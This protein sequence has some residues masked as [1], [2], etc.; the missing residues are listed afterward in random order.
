MPKCNYIFIA[1][2]PFWGG[3][4]TGIDMPKF[5]DYM[6]AL[7]KE[8]QWTALRNPNPEKGCLV[9]L[10]DDVT[11]SFAMEGPTTLFISSVL[12]ELPSDAIRRDSLL[13]RI[14]GFMVAVRRMRKTQLILRGDDLLAARRL[15]TVSSIPV[16]LRDVTD[17][18]N[19]VVWWKKAVD[20]AVLLEEKSEPESVSSLFSNSF[21]GIRL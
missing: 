19:D 3:Q 21:A 7:A 16:F 15:D 10:D 5:I 12:C 20:Q 2:P 18:V 9:E 6:R 13:K 8:T 1:S 17:W 4:F 11:L 14:G